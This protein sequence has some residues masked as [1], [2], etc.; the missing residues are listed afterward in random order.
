MDALR[1]TAMPAE[2]VAAAD[3]VLTSRLRSGRAWRHPE[4]PLHVI[5]PARDDVHVPADVDQLLDERL[6]ELLPNGAL[7]PQHHLERGLLACG[8]P[9]RDYCP[10][11]KPNRVENASRGPE[12]E[13]CKGLSER[14][15]GQLQDGVLRS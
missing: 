2:L 5:E 6:L 13:C 8:R 7:Q 12:I 4:G 3:E 11:S 10:S 15:L 14:L 9:V 1:S